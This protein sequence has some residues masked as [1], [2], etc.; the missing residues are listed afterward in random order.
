MKDDLLDSPPPLPPQNKAA[1][2]PL[3][4]GFGVVV[5]ALGDR[6]C[7]SSLSHEEK[8][9]YFDFDCL[10][11][12]GTPTSKFIKLQI[13]WRN[14]A[15]MHICT[16]I[17]VVGGDVGATSQVW[18]GPSGRSSYFKYILYKG[19]AFITIL[20]FLPRLIGHAAYSAKEA[21]ALV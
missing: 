2:L 3:P 1:S 12:G 14:S 21:N 9:A 8:F 10:G 13:C 16:K 17:V 5:V 4:S 11:L 7:A 18:R 20:N 15:L 19:S 6:E